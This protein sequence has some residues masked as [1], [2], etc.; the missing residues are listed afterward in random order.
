MLLALA[1]IC[2]FDIIQFDILSAY[3]HGI[4]KEQIYM[5]QPD[6]YAA[7]G[8]KDWVRRLRKGLYGLVQAG[9][10][11]SEEFSGHMEGEGYTATRK[12]PAIYIKSS[13]NR[14][15]LAAGGFWV[16]N[17]VGIGSGR[18]VRVLSKGVDVK[19]GIIGLGETKWILGVLLERDCSA[20]TI[21]ISQEAFIEMM[22]TRVGLTD[23]SG[24]HTSHTQYPP[25]CRQLPHHR[26]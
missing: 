18:E 12:D 6:G 2:D 5:E 21:S 23:E 25:F 15:D 1:A 17:L 9:R 4:L 7:P 24:Y 14:E 8:K 19:Y 3:L 22:L 10:T 26:G 13:W 11:W 16:D 20:R